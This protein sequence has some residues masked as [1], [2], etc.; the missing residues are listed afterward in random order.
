VSQTSSAA[1]LTVTD[2][3]ASWSSRFFTPTELSNS[4]ISGPTADPDADGVPN[5]LEFAFNL[6]PRIANRSVLIAGAGTTGL[7]LIRLETINNQKVLTIEFV[8]RRAAGS[9][10]ITYHAEFNSDLTNPSGWSETG[11]TT[12]TQIDDTW[13]RVKVTDSLVNQSRR[14][15]RVRITMP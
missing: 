4:Q 3:F 2:T 13:E 11:A 5:L 1:N 14:L 8:R 6:Q 10:G 12:I 7:P 9:P 15:G